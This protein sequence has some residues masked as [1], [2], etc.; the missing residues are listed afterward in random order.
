LPIDQS[1]EVEP[2]VHKHSDASRCDPGITR[3]TA[4]RAPC[5]AIAAG[6]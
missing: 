4:Q 3:E 5:D 2:A 6:L 1:Y